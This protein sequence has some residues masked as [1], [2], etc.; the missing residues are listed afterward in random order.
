M[1][2]LP[3][4]DTG[5]APEWLVAKQAVEDQLV[6]E[7]KVEA[8][9]VCRTIE[10]YTDG[11]APIANPGGPLGFAVVAVAYRDPINS[12]GQERPEPCAQI[13]LGGFVA[14]RR[15]EPRTS[16]NRAEIAGVLAAFQLIHK[17]GEN[18]AQPQHIYIWSDSKYTVFCGNG[19][20]QR[21]K[22]TDLWAAYDRALA[23]AKKSTGATIELGWV[24][25]HASN[26]Y[27]EVADELATL[28][29]FNFDEVAHKRFRA[30]QAA[31]G[32]EMPG[33][34]TLA[35][36]GVK[37]DAKV[38][39]AAAE[40]T[41]TDNDSE[42][43]ESK[44][45]YEWQSD[46]DYVVLLLT[47]LDGG[48]QSRMGYA[49]CTGTYRL[50]TSKGHSHQTKTRH[51]G[52]RLPDE[53]EYLTLLSALDDLTRRIK[54]AGRDP[55]TFTVTVFSGRELM[56]KQLS[57]AY[58]VKSQALKPLYERAKK[59]LGQFRRVEIILKPSAMLKNELR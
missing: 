10:V 43:T 35:Q 11:S 55:G 28:A 52:E 36:F 13:E 53:G 9:R 2:R 48:E 58:Q 8:F 3:N 22:N 59:A 16:N 19:V 31:T 50:T 20:W 7:D 26:Q 56:T 46:S 47:Q 24:K 38:S 5:E 33:D 32:R 17:L 39:E 25:G 45:P 40:E 44:Y 41:T 34:K 4:M 18:K 29:A 6:H 23:S 37:L 15:A 1:Q 54:A 49:P 27:N 57:G 42:Q 30:A 21:K 14:A 51:T 12:D